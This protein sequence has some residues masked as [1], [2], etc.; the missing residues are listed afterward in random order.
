MKSK[1][2]FTRIRS[3]CF[4]K[5]ELC[6]D[7]LTDAGMHTHMRKHSLINGARVVRDAV[8]EITLEIINDSHDMVRKNTDELTE[9]GKG[10]LL[11]AQRVNKAVHSAMLKVRM[12]E[13]ENEN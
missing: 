9:H 3:S 6:G 12:M 2:K 8:L 4:E 5:C 10:Q 1:P 13:K 11:T 7:M